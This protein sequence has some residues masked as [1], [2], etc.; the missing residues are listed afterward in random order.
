MGLVLPTAASR[1][2]VDAISAEVTIAVDDGDGG[3]AEEHHEHRDD[4]L[5]PVWGMTS[6]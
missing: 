1:C 6:P 5:N 3:D 4:L 2:C